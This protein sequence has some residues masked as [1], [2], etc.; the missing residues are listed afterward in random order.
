MYLYCY[1]VHGAQKQYKYNIFSQWWKVTKSVYSRA[2]LKYNFKVLVQEIIL[3]H[4][5]YA[6]EIT[7]TGGRNEFPP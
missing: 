7:D 2:V 4:F 6:N 1:A 5:P 3:Q